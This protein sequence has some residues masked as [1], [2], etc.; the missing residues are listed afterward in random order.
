M[1]K[2]YLMGTSV[3]TAAKTGKNYMVANLMDEKGR[4]QSLFMPEDV[5]KAVENSLGQLIT[6]DLE[7]LTPLD[8]EI[9]PF[10][11]QLLGLTGW[12]EPQK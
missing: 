7:N 4:R 2:V 8:A 3:R 11:N 10:N 5:A 9:D 6:K 1:L 12:A